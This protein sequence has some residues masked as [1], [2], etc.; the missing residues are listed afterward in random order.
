MY[1]I[2]FE[3]RDKFIVPITC[4]TTISE[5]EKLCNFILRIAHSKPSKI[6]N[7]KSV[8]FYGISLEIRLVL[9]IKSDLPTRWKEHSGWLPPQAKLYVRLRWTF[10]D[11]YFYGCHITSLCLLWIDSPN[12]RSKST[13]IYFIDISP[14]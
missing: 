2:S 11:P 8:L 12:Q 1:T 9:I 14:H 4:V 6:L 5:W 7:Y 10:V 13:E 3:V